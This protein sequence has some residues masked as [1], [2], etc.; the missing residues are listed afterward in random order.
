M[1]FSVSRALISVYDKTGLLDL[2]KFLI[3]KEVEIVSSGGTAKY[4]EEHGI[5]VIKVESLTSFPEILDGRVKTLNPKIHGA[6]LAKRDNKEHLETLNKF[7]IKP[8]DLVIVNL[9]PFE[10]EQTLENIDIG[11]PCLIRSAAK[12]YESVAI[13]VSPNQYKDFIENF[14]NNELNLENLKLYAKEAFKRTFNYDKEIYKYFNNEN[15]PEN[16]SIN[17]NKFQD[18]R[19]GENPHQKAILYKRDSQD[20]P[21]ILKSIQQFSGKELS[22]NNWL[23]IDSAW[24]LI[25]EFEAE[26][27]ACVIIKHNIP[28]GVALGETIEQ[29]YSYAL[30]CDPLSAFGGIVAFNNIIDKNTAKKL[31]ETFLEVIIATDFEVEALDILKEKKNL[32]L[33]KMDLMPQNLSFWQFKSILGE[34]LLCQSFNSQ[35]LNHDDLKVISEIQPDKEDWLSLLFAFKIVKHVK[36]N[37]I[38]I[39]NGNRTVGICGGQTSRID[40]VK[41]ALEKASD[42]TN[43]AV[44]ASD[45]FFPFGDSVELC[46]QHKIKAI[47]QPGGSV[48]DQESI[49]MA[50]KYKIAMVFTKIRHFKH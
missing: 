4:L 21:E 32:R 38:V 9:Y 45:A 40:A 44:L 28:C 7:E 6:I 3:S 24:S 17:L 36:S 13:L 20:C 15:E 41:I 34:G 1:K 19:Y 5:K 46:A 10:K 31:K 43:G 11:G 8:I 42:L 33:I 22:Y 50:N 39:V 16:Q 25:S 37:A 48:R 35:L 49:D 2:A 14:K 27:P 12:N 29:A 30:D 26:I 23:D 47:I 18:L